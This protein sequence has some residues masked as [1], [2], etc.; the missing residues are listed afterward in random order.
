MNNFLELLEA[1]Q[2]LEQLISESI[3]ELTVSEVNIL[4]EAGIVGNTFKKGKR[5]VQQVMGD[6]KN[7]QQN[8]AELK[9]VVDSYKN[10]DS[11]PT[12]FIN[13]ILIGAHARHRNDLVDG[14]SAAR[15]KAAIMGAGLVTAGT[16]TVGVA[17][18]AKRKRAATHAAVTKLNAEKAAAIKAEHERI[19]KSKMSYKIKNALGLED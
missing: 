5:F 7:I 13:N 9:S 17:D 6:K 3:T 14:V 12:R 18:Y 8:A 1:K 19:R 4:N 15:R 2:E 10:S 16:G 11:F